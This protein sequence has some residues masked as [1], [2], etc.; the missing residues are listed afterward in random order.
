MVCILLWIITTGTKTVSCSAAGYV[1]QTET[2]VVEEGM[3]ATLDFALVEEEVPP[4]AGIVFEDDFEDYTAGEMLACQN[5]EDWT[6]WALDPCG[7]DDAYVSDDVAY[8]GANSFNVVSGDDVVKELDEY[9]TSGTHTL[10]V[11][12]YVPSGG[13]GYY[14]ILS[15]FTP[16]PEWAFEVYFNAGGDAAVSAGGTGAATFNYAFDTW[17]ESKVVVD[18]NADWAEYFVD[19]NSIIAWQWTAGASGGGNALSIGALDFYGP[20]ATSSTYFDDLVISSAEELAAPTDF[21]AEVVGGDDVE[22]NWVAPGGLGYIQWDAG[23]NTGNGIGLTNGGAFLVASRWLPSDLTPYDGNYMTSITI[24]PNQDPAATYV[25]K[26][27]TGANA[28]TEILSQVVPS[29][30]I[31][32]FNEIALETPIM[33]DASQELWFGYECTH[34]AGTFPAGCDDGPAV[35]EFGDQISLDGATWTGMSAA[36]GLDYNWNIAGYLTA[37]DNGKAI[38]V[39]MVKQTITPSNGSPVASGSNGTTVKMDNNA[40]KG[41]IGFNVYR[42]G[43]VIAE[44]IGESTYTDMDLAPGT[45]TFEVKAV[46]DEGLSASAEP[47][48][49]TLEIGDLVPRDHVIVE[50]GTGTWCQYCPGAAMGADEMHEEGFSCWYH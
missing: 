38:A 20:N 8:S 7:A 24:Y 31:D 26:A 41:F 16:A 18:L 3:T 46:Y 35:Q 5:P 49:E 2:V 27:W 33:I 39:P 43:A 40:T 11:M 21:T 1:N 10:S 50:I 17:I 42:D 22:M 9:L 37:S 23:T 14:N 6:T 25:L 15:A 29:V 45:Y 34:G 36:Y 44:E 13:D 47:G 48:P 19:G 4:P 30:T 12:V 32:Q 28:G